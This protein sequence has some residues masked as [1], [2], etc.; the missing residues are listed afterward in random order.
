MFSNDGSTDGTLKVIEKLRTEFP[1]RISIHQLQ[2][3]NGKA[4]AV[5][6]A[7]LSAMNSSEY[8]FVGFWDADLATPLEEC[9]FFR[10]QM[11]ANGKKI[12][13]GSRMKRL[14]ALVERKRSRHL[15]GRVFSTFSSIILKLPVYDTQCGAKVFSADLQY[16][17]T[18]KFTTKWLFD[19]EMIARYR[20]KNG[21]TG[22]LNDI[23]EIPI[24][25]W[26]EKG[27]S[28]LKFSHMLKVPFELIR[29]RSMYNK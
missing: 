13:I 22:A 14:G 9:I 20:N 17:F 19:I 24:G 6:T 23:I 1:D 4:E 3:N 7:M 18:E 28:K 12:A 21:I 16:L 11:V 29:I 10:E 25:Q 5:R 2:V 8:T 26:K 15:L 27:G